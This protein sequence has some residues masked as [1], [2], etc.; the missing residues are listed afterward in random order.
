MEARSLRAALEQPLVRAY[1]QRLLAH[2][3]SDYTWKQCWLDYR[4]AAIFNLFW[5]VFHWRF[6]GLPYHIWRPGLKG[7]LDAFEDLRCEELLA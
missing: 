6:G 3:V 1:H 2:G 5:P 4:M 7:A